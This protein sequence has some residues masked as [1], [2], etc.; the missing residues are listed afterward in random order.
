MRKFLAR[1]ADQQANAL[2]DQGGATWNPTTT[3]PYSLLRKS[4]QCSASTRRPLRA[5]PAPA[6]SPRFARS[7]DTVD[8]VRVRSANSSSK[9]KNPTASEPSTIRGLERMRGGGR[10]FFAPTFPSLGFPFQTSGRDR[11]RSGDPAL[12]RRVLCRL[13]YP[14]GVSPFRTHCT[15]AVLTGFEPAASA[16]TGRRALQTAPQDQVST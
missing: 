9:S 11:R 1:P 8:S 6:R 4:R 10:A 5:G 2:D 16:L 13:S 3:T 7:A 12:F 14:A 15:C